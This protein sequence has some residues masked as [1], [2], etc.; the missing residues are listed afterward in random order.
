[1]RLARIVRNILAE[2]IQFFPVPHNAIITLHLTETLAA[3]LA[4]GGQWDRATELAERAVQLAGTPSPA[5]SADEAA[6][7]PDSIA[8]HELPPHWPRH[9][10]PMNVF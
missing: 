4:A 10:V 1:M 8:R 5:E 7:I 3:V 9:Q 6:Q 2:H